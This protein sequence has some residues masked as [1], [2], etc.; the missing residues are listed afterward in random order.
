MRKYHPRGQ[1]SHWS[2]QSLL[3]LLLGQFLGL[4]LLVVLS[5]ALLYLLESLLKLSHALLLLCKLA[6]PY[7]ACE[8]IGNLGLLASPDDGHLPCVLFLGLL[9]GETVDTL[10]SVALSRCVGRAGSHFLIES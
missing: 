9:L 6:S 5:L 8:I 2:L 4:L 3:L 7:L 10:G 1:I